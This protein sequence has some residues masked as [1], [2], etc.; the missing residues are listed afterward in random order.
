MKNNYIADY[1]LNGRNVKRQSLPIQDE[2]E[3]D[4]DFQHRMSPNISFMIGTCN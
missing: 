2:P 3:G 4:I 1:I